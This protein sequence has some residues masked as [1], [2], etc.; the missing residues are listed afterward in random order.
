MRIGYFQFAPR[1]GEPEHNLSALTAAVSGARADLVVA[2]ELALS[3]YL[4]TGKG[5]VGWVPLDSLG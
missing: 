1:F 2:P 5:E 4:F 3:G